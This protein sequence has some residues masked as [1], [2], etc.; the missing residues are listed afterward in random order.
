MYVQVA[1]YTLLISI[2]RWI[3]F[4]A[5]YEPFMDVNYFVGFFILLR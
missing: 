3:K 1:T 4:F 2:L 5:Y